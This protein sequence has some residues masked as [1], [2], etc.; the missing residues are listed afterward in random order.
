MYQA[1]ADSLP[2]AFGIVLATLPLMAVPLT[3]VSRGAMRVLGGF[4]AG[5]AGGFVGLAGVVILS[6]DLL[7]YATA[8]AAR[9]TIWLRL[10]LG[11]ALLGLAAHKWRGRPRGDEVAAPPAWVQMLD[12]IGAPGALG[13][14]FVL[15]VLNPKNALLVAS[16]ALAIAAATPV[17]AAQAVALLVFSAVSCLGVAAPLLLWLVLGDRVRAPLGRLRGLL[18]RYDAQILTVV[19]AAL[20]LVIIFNAATA[21][22]APA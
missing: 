16:G 6:A 21:A 14:G 13:L 19:L 20:G 22:A 12:R 18:V 7:A 8:D 3:L 9:W 10:L 2:I 5:Y 15:V 4:L 1:L 17:P 11:V